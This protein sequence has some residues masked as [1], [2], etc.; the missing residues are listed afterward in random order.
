[1]RRQCF[2]H[3]SMIVHYHHANVLRPLIHV[4]T[5]LFRLRSAQCGY[6]SNSIDR[7]HAIYGVN[8]SDCDEGN[9]YVISQI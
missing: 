6:S 7:C 1:L 3:V 2:E 4:R 5:I 9:S 8:L